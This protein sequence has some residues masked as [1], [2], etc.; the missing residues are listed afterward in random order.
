MTQVILSVLLAL[1]HFFMQKNWRKVHTIESYTKAQIREKKHISIEKIY[2]TFNS[3]IPNNKI[4][5]GF[6]NFF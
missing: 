4:V 5:R 6:E 1:A 3:D 2:P